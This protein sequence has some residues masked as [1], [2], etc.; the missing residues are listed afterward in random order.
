MQ[1]PSNSG[2]RNVKSW[3]KKPLCNDSVKRR[4]RSEEQSV[5]LPLR[6]NHRR[7]PPHLGESQHHKVPLLRLRRAPKVLPLLRAGTGLVRSALHDP[8]SNRD[9]PPKGP[10]P[11][12]PPGPKIRGRGRDH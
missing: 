3:T 1:P 10:L 4:L 12:L 8:S 5:I 6:V 9:N 7:F 2:A 11:L